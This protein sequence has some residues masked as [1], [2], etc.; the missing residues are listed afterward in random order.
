MLPEMIR[1]TVILPFL[2]GPVIRQMYTRY[3][4]PAQQV[5]HYVAIVQ[6]TMQIGSPAPRR[7]PVP[8]RLLPRINGEGQGL[9]S[10]P[11]HL[12]LTHMDLVP[13]TDRP[14]LRQE[15]HP[16]PHRRLLP[17][18]YGMYRQQPDPVHRLRFPFHSIGI[19]DR[20]PH[21]LVTA[22]NA[23]HDDTRGLRR[24]D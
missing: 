21:H 23:Y 16:P 10:M 20:Q 6:Y 14:L 24:P 12:R 19:G 2:E 3:P 18:Q 8:V 7:Y 1:Q 5:F 9:Q 4:R 13:L 17:G 11:V 15:T 22:A